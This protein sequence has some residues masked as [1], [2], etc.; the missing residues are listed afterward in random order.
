MTA[1]AALAGYPSLVL[2][3]SGAS[4]LPETS[5]PGDVMPSVGLQNLL[6]PE[7]IIIIIIILK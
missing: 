2:S 6:S 1:G 3:I 5:F 7:I 4:Q